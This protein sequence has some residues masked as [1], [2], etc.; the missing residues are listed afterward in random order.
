MSTKPTGTMS[1]A[2]RNAAATHTPNLDVSG[3]GPLVGSRSPDGSNTT[4][5]SLWSGRK[6]PLQPPD[7][8]VARSIEFLGGGDPLAHK[9]RL[10]GTDLGLL[11]HNMACN[12]SEAAV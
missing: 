3:N 9:N 2:G 7:S 11:L 8:F 4:A 10:H 12:F 1:N 5:S 6:S